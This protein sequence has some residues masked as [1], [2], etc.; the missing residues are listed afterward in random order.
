MYRAPL[1]VAAI[2]L[3]TAAQAATLR[4]LTTLAAPVVRLCDL[5]DDAGPHADRVLGPG[6]AP[7]GRIV[8]EAAQLAAIARQFGVDW[9]PGSPVDRAVLERPGELLPR[10]EVM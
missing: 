4:P 2:T 10:D 8:I 6:P 1:F 9:R 7:G 5:F 3:A